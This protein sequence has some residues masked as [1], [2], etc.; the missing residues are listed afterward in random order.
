MREI[1]ERKKENISKRLKKGGR[2]K[3]NNKRRRRSLLDILDLNWRDE[4]S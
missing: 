3:D 1:T 4:K 2:E